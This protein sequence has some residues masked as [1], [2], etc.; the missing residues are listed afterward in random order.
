MKT[1]LLFLSFLLFQIG[2]SQNIIFSDPVF[3][4]FLVN[5]NVNFNTDP[6][7]IVSYPPIDANDDGEISQTEALSVIGLEFYYTNITDLEGLQ[8]FTNVKV[9]ST[10]YANFPVFNQ[11]SLVN[12]EELSL[13]NFVGSVAL[14]TVNVSNNINLIKFQCS[15]DLITS[16]DFSNNTLLKDVTI[17]CPSLI[18][19]NFSNLVNLK[20]LSYLGKLPTIDISDSINLLYLQ[21]IGNSGT[22][23]VPE[24]N[25]L[26]SIDLTNQAKLINLD[27]SGNNLTSLDLSNC[28]N[29]E[30]IYISKNQIS[31]LNIDNVNYVK[32]FHCD[33]NLLTSLNVDGM[34]NLQLFV[35]KNNLL[36]S[37]SVRNDIIEDFIDFSGNPDLA[38]ICCDANEVVYIQNQ[39]LLNDN[40]ATII[41][42][43]CSTGSS[44][45]AMYP[46]PV[47]DV[48]HLTSNKKITKIEI[49]AM[50]GLMIMNNELESDV[51]NLHQLE[52]GMYI[53]KVYTDS[54]V[55]NM[56]FIKV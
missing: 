32:T 48:L 18:S 13:L 50:N 16:L 5:A 55:T 51:V 3:K 14:T 46:N 29:L 2:N 36:T 28:P 45:I 56:K 22:Y 33:D 9:I 37:L 25:L 8:Y 49:I 31:T 6:N 26:T 47:N 19:V 42:S 23:Y 43:D 38:S 52:S 20:N 27:L 54:E 10:Y 15:S 12:L 53:I 44:K 30:T 7:N 11:P 34:F 4:D 21:V 39:C 24:E 40:D 35:C 41:N 1:T 17:Y